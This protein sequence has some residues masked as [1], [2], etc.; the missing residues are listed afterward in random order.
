MAIVKPTSYTA[1]VN[2]KLSGSTYTKGT[3]IPP[4]VM[5]QQHNANMLVS[6]GKVKPLPDPHRRRG[7]YRRRPTT[8][9]NL[10]QK[11]GITRGIEMGTTTR[12]DDFDDE[13]RNTLTE[14]GMEATKEQ[15]EKAGEKFN[16]GVADLKATGDPTDF[17]QE[18]VRT[19]PEHKSEHAADD[20]LYPEDTNDDADNPGVEPGT[21]GQFDDE[22]GD[23]KKDK[24]DKKLKAEHKGDGPHPTQAEKD[25]AA[26]RQAK[27]SP[28]VTPPASA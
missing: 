3:A 22:D 5:Q 24:K 20:D 27:E 1:Q 13:P 18:R 23:G 15:R 28:R 8:V 14:T 10:L 26:T 25:A 6:S 11:T 12:D 2:L 7:P 17:S 21:E 16:K 4:A 9:H 19:T